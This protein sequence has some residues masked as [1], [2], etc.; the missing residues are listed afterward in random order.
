MI[1]PNREVYNKRLIKLPVTVTQGLTHPGHP[2]F[3]PTLHTLSFDP[4]RIIWQRLG[5]PGRVG[6]GKSDFSSTVFRG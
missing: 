4:T 1:K 3:L 2:E 6:V 5:W